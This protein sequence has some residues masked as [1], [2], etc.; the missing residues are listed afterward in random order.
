MPYLK[1]VTEKGTARVFISVA[2]HIPDAVKKLQKDEGGEFVKASP[3]E[4]LDDYSRRN[5]GLPDIGPEPEEKEVL[6]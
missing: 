4:Y 1:L 5:N 6:L 2:G 3:D